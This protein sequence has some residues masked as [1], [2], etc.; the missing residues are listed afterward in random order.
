VQ[1]LTLVL[2][3][4]GAGFVHA[5]GVLPRQG[6]DAPCSTAVP[7]CVSWER[8]FTSCQDLAC[9]CSAAVSAGT[10]CGDACYITANPSAYSFL[11]TLA[12][13]C[14]ASETTGVPSVITPAPTATDNIVGGNECNTG[15][16]ACTA[17][18]SSVANCA[19][20][21]EACQCPIILEY[22][23]ACSM[24]YAS[25]EP[26]IASAYSAIISA[27]GGT[28]GG[29]V[30]TPTG[31][32]ATTGGNTQTTAATGSL[33]AKSTTGSPNTTKSTSGAS[34]YDGL[35]GFSEALGI[36]VF[37]FMGSLMIL[38]FG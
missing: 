30:A 33:N 37:L 32:A 13:A 4:L 9:E 28:G 26:E 3:F 38:F 18:S 5:A 29:R 19:V 23:P 16:P 24:C 6:T 11:S 14:I 2:S 21:D 31:G 34:R 15:N 27:C 1:S 12:S 20:T 35:F 25:Y 17:F 7:A 22:G 8:A 36:S 10:Q